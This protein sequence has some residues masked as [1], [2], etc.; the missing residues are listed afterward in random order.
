M[1]FSTRNDFIALQQSRVA[2]ATKKNEEQRGEK[3]KG[4][5]QIICRETQVS[6][7]RRRLIA[8]H[9]RYKPRNREH[10][11]YAAKNAQEPGRGTPLI[12]VPAPEE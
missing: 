11:Q 6:A 12:D 8:E 9:L 5:D 3:K 2:S 1:P 7:S 4:R 10:R